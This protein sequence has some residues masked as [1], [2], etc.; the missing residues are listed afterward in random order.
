MR[1]DFNF[2]CSGFARKAMQSNHRS[3]AI[4]GAKKVLFQFEKRNFN[5][6]LQLSEN[7]V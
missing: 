7:L 3:V 6:T 2:C 5:N 1:M 4:L